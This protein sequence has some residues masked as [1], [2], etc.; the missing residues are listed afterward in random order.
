M[1]NRYVDAVVVRARSVLSPSVCR[2]GTSVKIK[3]FQPLKR[4]PCSNRRATENL[5]CTCAVT[6]LHNKVSYLRT[7]LYTNSQVR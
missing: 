1:Y 4:I 7:R 3:Y 5:Y 6:L 2:A